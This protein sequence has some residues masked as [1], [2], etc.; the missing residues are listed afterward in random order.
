MHINKKFGKKRMG[1][2]Y[3]ILFILAYNHI[4]INK[5]V[6]AH[7]QTIKKVI[8]QLTEWSKKNKLYLVRN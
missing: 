5:M 7:L 6:Y 2:F 3:R 1:P 8:H 4:V